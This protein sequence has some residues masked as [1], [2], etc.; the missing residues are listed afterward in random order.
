[1]VHDG[2]STEPSQRGNNSDLQEGQVISPAQHQRGQVPGRST[3]APHQSLRRDEDRP[4]ALD[5]RPQGPDSRRGL[6]SSVAAQPATMCIANSPG[7]PCR[8]TGPCRLRRPEQ[9]RGSGWSARTAG[10][11]VRNERTRREA[12]R[13]TLIRKNPAG[14]WIGRGG[15]DH[16]RRNVTGLGLCRQDSYRDCLLARWRPRGTAEQPLLVG[17]FRWSA[18]RC[19]VVGVC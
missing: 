11:S 19:P 4:L 8:Q 7:W 12:G 2:A 17:P 16:V 18:E 14:H 3:S 1:M 13:T 10:V 15:S 5:A 6:T 9:R